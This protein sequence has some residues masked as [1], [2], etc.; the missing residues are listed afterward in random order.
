MR[1][2]Y[3]C[4]AESTGANSKTPVRA[5]TKNEELKDGTETPVELGKSG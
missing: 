2:M 4:F 3:Y 5:L 1:H